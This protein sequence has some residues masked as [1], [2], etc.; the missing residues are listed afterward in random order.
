MEVCGLEVISLAPPGGVPFQRIYEK[1][2]G[3]KIEANFCQSMF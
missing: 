3:V 2:S 1:D